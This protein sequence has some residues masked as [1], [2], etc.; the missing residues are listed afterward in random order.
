MKK[1]RKNK[2]GITDKS[3]K[4]WHELLADIKKW[5]AAGCPLMSRKEHDRL[6]GR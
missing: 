3:V 6:Y 2:K 5:E 1:P 4:R